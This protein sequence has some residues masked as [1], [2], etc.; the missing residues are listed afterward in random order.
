MYTGMQGGR[1]PPEV[2]MQRVLDR[3][4]EEE[5][6]LTREEEEIL[7]SKERLWEKM[8]DKRVRQATAMKIMIEEEEERKTE[9]CHIGQIERMEKEMKELGKIRRNTRD[10]LEDMQDIV[11]YKSREMRA[12]RAEERIDGDEL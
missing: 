1:A 4:Q 2:N 5:V 10:I 9:D 6:T 8:N 12:V 11:Y 7:Q 3:H